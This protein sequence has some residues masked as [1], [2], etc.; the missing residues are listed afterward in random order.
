MKDKQTVCINQYESRLRYLRM[1]KIIY[2]RF[3]E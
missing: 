3:K 2:R 1:I